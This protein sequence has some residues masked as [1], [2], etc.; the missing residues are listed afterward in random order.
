MKQ[1]EMEVKEC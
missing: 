1:C